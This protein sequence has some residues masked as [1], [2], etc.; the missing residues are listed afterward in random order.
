MP[1]RLAPWLALLA[2]I[3]ALGAAP[4]QA[5][6]E[7]TG[8]PTALAMAPR[9][10]GITVE[11]GGDLLLTAVGNAGAL[12][13]PELPRW[14]T[15]PNTERTMTMSVRQSRLGVGLGLP[16]DGL[17]ASARLRALVE[18]DFAGGSAGGDDA[19][20][21][22]RLRQA[23]L[24]A[25]WEE[26][27]RL[28]LLVG[29]ADGLM[30]G[31]TQP[32]SQGHYAIPRFTG[33]GV[34]YR[35]APQLRLAVEPG[36]DWRVGVAAAALAPNDRNV[37]AVPPTTTPT[38]VGVR[39]GAPDLEA[40]AW[41]GWWREGRRRLEIGL[42][43]HYGR[44]KYWLGGAPGQPDGLLDA[45]GAAVDARLE[46]GPVVVAGAAWRGQDLDVLNTAGAGTAF[47]YVLN[48]QNQPVLQGVRAVRVSGAWGQAQWLAVEGLR[49]LLGGGVERSEK[50]DLPV[51]SAVA[52]NL[53]ASAGAL[54]D[55]TGR[56]RA[57]LE[58]TGYWT[59]TTAGL[60]THSTQVELT[61][62]YAF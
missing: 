21:V 52:R 12:D 58:L 57:G 61:S 60:E 62:R 54:L 27:W 25:A 35:R 50:R 47:S 33:A 49:L 8:T 22:P 18:L 42:S 53:Q 5:E 30:G 59:T 34:L 2:P 19:T 44:E 37:A 55:L 4:P 3:A 11:L 45:W 15:Y 1:R 32:E 56:W 14:A 29:Q 23:W 26:R 38:G 43:G 39:S 16:A 6:P 36:G 10:P 48:A 20:P 51:G 13:A 7:P 24:A 28:S 41:V 9:R 40:R 31:P 17:L 46:L